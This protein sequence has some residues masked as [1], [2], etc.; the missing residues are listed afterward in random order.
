MTIKLTL[1]REFYKFSSAM[2]PYLSN[3]LGKDFKWEQ[4]FGYT[5]ITF[6]NLG[7]LKEFIEYI[8]DLQFIDE[9]GPKEYYKDEN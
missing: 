7:Q 6:D 4:S 2:Y 8:E 5:N 3:V 9:I 1:D